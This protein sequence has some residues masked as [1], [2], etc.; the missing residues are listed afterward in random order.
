MNDII[1]IVG[2]TNSGKNV[3]IVI[4]KRVRGRLAENVV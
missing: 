1:I 4:I 2:L 3:I